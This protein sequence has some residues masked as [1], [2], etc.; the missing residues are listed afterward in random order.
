MGLLQ[1]D[2]EWFAC[3]NE[4]KLFTNGNSL[5]LLFAMTLIHNSVINPTALWENFQHHICDDL[6]HKIQ[7]LQNINIPEEAEDLHLD[8]GLFL[9]AA[10]LMESGKKLSDYNLPQSIFP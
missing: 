7:N 9:I 6:N 2:G 8:Y 1:N 5:R 3:F 4:A 10:I